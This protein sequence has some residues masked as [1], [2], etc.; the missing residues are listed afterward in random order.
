MPQGSLGPADVCA[1]LNRRGY[2]ARGHAAEVYASRRLRKRPDVRRVIR[3]QA[4]TVIERVNERA[5]A[6]YARRCAGLR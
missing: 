4:A 5:R 1:L 3:E 6:D 2:W